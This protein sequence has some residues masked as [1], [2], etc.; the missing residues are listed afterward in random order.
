M[1]SRLRHTTLLIIEPNDIARDQYRSALKPLG[2]SFIQTAT[3]ASALAIVEQMMPDLVITELM[4]PD[5]SGVDLLNAFDAN[6]KLRVVPIIAVS[7]AD[8]Q[9]QLPPAAAAEFADCLLKPIDALRLRAVVSRIL[10]QE[11]GPRASGTGTAR[12]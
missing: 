8:A 4:L 6:P 9:A 11:S 5:L 12:G 1:L 7:N 10:G 2:C 3:G